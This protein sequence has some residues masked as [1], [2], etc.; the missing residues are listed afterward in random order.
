MQAGFKKWIEYCHA[1]TEYQKSD[2]A[3]G[4]TSDS[5]EYEYT[6]DGKFEVGGR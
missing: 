1:E 5:N 2:E 3:F 6:E 4:E